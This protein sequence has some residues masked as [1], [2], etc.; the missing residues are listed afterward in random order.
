VPVSTVPPPTYLDK[1]YV[2]GKDDKLHLKPVSRNGVDTQIR[3]GT[4]VPALDE[5]IQGAPQ[6]FPKG[7]RILSMKS[8]G[9]VFTLDMNAAFGNTKEWNKGEATTEAAIYALV[10]S[11][12]QVDKSLK[13]KVQLTVEGKPVTA[14]GEMDT[15]E[16]FE[17]DKTLVGK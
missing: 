10:N 16:P 17:F 5:I 12:A 13:T 15:E 11:T 4:P 14:L 7:T 9:K 3:A 2:P 1:I 8:D 6:Y